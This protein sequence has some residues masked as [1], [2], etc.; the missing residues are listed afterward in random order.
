VALAW[1]VYDLTRSAAAL[2]WLMVCYTGP[3]VVGGFFAGWLLDRFDRRVVMIADNL[4]RGGTMALVPILA[5][6]GQLALWH[7]YAAAAV[8]GFLMM[9]ALAGGPS[10]IPSLVRPDQLATANALEMLAF[11]IGGVLGPVIAGLLI[12]RIGAPNIVILDVASYFIYALLLARIRGVVTDSPAEQ[13]STAG[14]GLEHA[15]RLL[16]TNPIL[17]AT[18]LM[19]LTFNIGGARW[20]S[21]CRFSPTNA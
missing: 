6:T 12:D 1:L 15:I 2:G 4:I 8:Y 18:T 19:F 21:G 7:L 20:R 11:T 10:L 5:A 17:L 14:L 16:L 3:I 13:K 9:I